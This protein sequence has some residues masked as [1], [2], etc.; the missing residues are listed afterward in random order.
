LC[1]LIAS[2]PKLCTCPMTKAVYIVGLVMRPVQ[3]KSEIPNGNWKNRTEPTIFEQPIDLFYFIYFYFLK[4]IIET[5]TVVSDWKNRKPNRL[6]NFHTVASLV[7]YIVNTIM[8][9]IFNMYKMMNTVYVHNYALDAI[10]SHSTVGLYV[11][12]IQYTQSYGVH[13]RTWLVCKISTSNVLKTR[14]RL[15]SRKKEILIRNYVWT[16]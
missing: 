4:P 1:E 5:E 10:N 9:M 12:C 3:F 11:I 2:R 6:P 16:R 14:S 7:A 8:Y 15:R 13:D